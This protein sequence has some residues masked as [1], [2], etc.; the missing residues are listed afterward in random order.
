MNGGE[1]HEGATRER[2]WRGIK[3][4]L[5]APST[6]R[7]GMRDLPRFLTVEDCEEGQRF[8]ITI[9]TARRTWCWVA[10]LGV[11]AL[12][13]LVIPVLLAWSSLGWYTDNRGNFYDASFSYG[14]FLLGMAFLV[15]VAWAAWWWAF[16]RIRITADHENIRVHNRIYAWGRAEGFRLGYSLG[17]VERVDKQGPYAGLRLAYGPWGDDLPFLVRHYYAPAYVVFLNDALKA[18]EPRTPDTVAESGIKPAMF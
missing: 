2:I 18:I 11:A 6:R 13:V 7:I 17:G 8:T 16:P 3:P 1:Q 9:P 5:P 14:R 4:P 10:M 15:A 12:W